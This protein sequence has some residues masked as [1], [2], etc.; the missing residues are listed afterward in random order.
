VLYLLLLSCAYLASCCTRADLALLSINQSLGLSFDLD[1]IGF[2]SPFQS[3][4]EVCAC[5]HGR[6]T[7]KGKVR[8]EIPCEQTRQRERLDI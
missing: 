3:A 2:A 8:G 6:E 7:Q 5:T 1:L 4:L